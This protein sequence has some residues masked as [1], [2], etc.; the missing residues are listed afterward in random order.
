MFGEQHSYVAAS[1]GN[2]GTVLQAQGRVRRGGAATI[3]KRWR[4]TGRCSARSTATSP[5]TLNNLG[6]LRRLERRPARGRDRTSVRRSGWR[7]RSLGDDH[8]NTI[9]VTSISAARCEAE[10]NGA[11]AER[12]CGEPRASS[13][14]PTRATVRWYVNAQT[15]LGLVLVGGGARGRGS[16]PARADGRVGPP[17]SGRGAPPHPGRAARAGTGAAGEPGVRHGRAGAAGGGRHVRATAEEPAVLRGAGR[18]R[19]GRA[20]EAPRGVSGDPR[21]SAAGSG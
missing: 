10:G 18:G 13:T 14:P 7:R 9:A 11:E 3:A 21:Y 16:G 8:L 20:S 19:A 5:P 12:C 17:A 15:G 1:L 6:N 4:S 2:L